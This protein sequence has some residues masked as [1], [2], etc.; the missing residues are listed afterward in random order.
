[1]VIPIEKDINLSY[2]F[3]HRN[4]NKYETL[5]EHISLCNNYL[6]EL[7]ENNN[8]DIVFY[9]L[10]SSLNLEKGTIKQNIY[11]VIRYHDYGKSNP[12]FQKMIRGERYSG[13]TNHSSL[14]SLI[15]LSDKLESYDTKEDIGY[16][17]FYI[18]S[19]LISK[20]HSNLS[21]ILKFKDTLFDFLKSI[22]D[23]DKFKL[24]DK[25]SIKFFDRVIKSYKDNFPLYIYTRLAFS[26]LVT[27][28]IYATKSFYDKD[29]SVDYGC[30]D[31]KKQW[32]EDYNSNDVIKGIRNR[33]AKEGINKY[34]TDIFL[35][36]EE[37]LNSNLNSRLFQLEAPTGSGKTLTGINL[38]L[39]LI[40]QKEELNKL[41]YVFPYNNLVEQTKNVFSNLY[42]KSSLKNEIN[43]LNSITSNAKEEDNYLDTI[44]NKEF[45]NYQLTLTTNIRLFKILFGTSKS[46]LYGFLR[47]CN[48]V[49]L[50]DEIQSYNNYIWKDIA[51]ALKEFSKIMN[52]NILIMSATLPDLNNYC[53]NTYINLLKDSSKY[54][55]NSIFKNRVVVDYSLIESDN[56]FEDILDKINCNKNSSIIIEF[57]KKKTA[58]EFFSIIE[59]EIYNRNLYYI[60]GD[61]N[62]FERKLVIESIKDDPNAILVGTQA[63]EAGL[64]IDM[65]IGLKDVSFLDSDEQFMGRVGR[66]ATKQGVVYFFDLDKVTTIYTNDYRANFK[67][68]EYK[69]YLLNKTFKDYYKQVADLQKSKGLDILLNM[70]ETEHNMKL[71]DGDQKVSIFKDIEVDNKIIDIVKNT[72]NFKA[73]KKL[74]N[75]DKIDANTLWNLLRETSRNYKFEE[76]K[77]RINVL[78]EI[79]QIYM[80]DYYEYEANSFYYS[81]ELLGI[82]FLDYDGSGIGEII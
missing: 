78:M 36:A 31:N 2:I 48:S 53:E 3:A 76:K 60:D 7:V 34:R 63:I 44:L 10:D 77:Y 28:D 12:K 47:L 69:E 41:F 9:N 56:V 54:T 67:F 13:S 21:N 16:A 18:N 58:K 17:L 35:E 80:Y 19:Y 23:K 75:T 55:Q 37:E 6:D 81:D 71:I 66:N 73:Y 72:E 59:N 50:I 40:E 61:T 15:Y 20:H 29:F 46:D 43:V 74:F 38:S 82:K 79:M 68:D 65:D 24:I 39:K 14:S 62:V 49:V 8:L 51:I 42:S 11:E 26:L 57:I 64:D 25:N 70:R 52:I 22:D 5:E 30:I 4:D 1:M 27:A 33:V 45:I 32:V